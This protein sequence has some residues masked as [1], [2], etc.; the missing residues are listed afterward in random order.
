MAALR[1]LAAIRARLL[2][3]AEIAAKVGDRI[4]PAEVIAVGAAAE[5]ATEDQ[6]RYPAITFAQVAGR[7]SV[8]P[9]ITLDPAVVMLQ[10]Y[11]KV[12]LTEAL[13]LY[14]LAHDALHNRKQQASSTKFCFADIREVGVAQWQWIP[15]DSVWQV[16][17]RFQLRGSVLV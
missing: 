14:E 15:E 13:D 10:F 11:S 2:G 1:H 7:W 17:A 6:P 9:E 16:S 3:I 4:Y 5:I 12:S 8:S